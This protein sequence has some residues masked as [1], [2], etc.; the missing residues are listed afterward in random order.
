M[1]PGTVVRKVEKV[2]REFPKRFPLRRQWDLSVVVRCTNPHVPHEDGEEDHHGRNAPRSTEFHKIA[3]VVF[4]LF[5][6]GSFDVLLFL[7]LLR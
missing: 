4:G 1:R 2:S 5:D 3:V 7:L 6:V